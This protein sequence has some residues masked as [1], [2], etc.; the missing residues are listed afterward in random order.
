MTG[1]LEVVLSASVIVLSLG[2]AG[3]TWLSLHRTGNR[4][5]IFVTA[6]FLAFSLKGVLTAAALFT[7]L[8]LVPVDVVLLGLDLAILLLLYL[9]LIITK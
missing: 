5:L 4:R 2:L 8:V 3:T 9:S 7:A 6:A 1:A